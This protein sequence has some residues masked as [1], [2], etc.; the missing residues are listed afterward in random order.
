MAEKKKKKDDYL[1]RGLQKIG[2]SLG[3]VSNPDV[4]AVRKEAYG[5]K[6]PGTPRQNKDVL[7]IHGGYGV[8]AYNT[9]RKPGWA[10]PR[11]RNESKGG[12]RISYGESTNASAM[13]RAELDA[14]RARLPKASAPKVSGKSAASSGASAS[15]TGSAK[16]SRK[17]TP[18]YAERRTA[19]QSVQENY[20]KEKAAKANSKASATT[21]AA[22]SKKAATDVP[23][24]TAKPS[25]AKG[26]SSPPAYTP[27]KAKPQ[28]G[29]KVT[30][31]VVANWTGAG[32]TDM[33]KRGG[34]RIDRGG[35]L[36]GKL[37]KK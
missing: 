32:A 34:A 13:D 26:S 18:S 24:P 16:V 23:K 15:G 4:D 27:E 35:G 2:H 19:M 5:G 3:L 1:A 17:S 14:A 33:Q 28:L 25:M 29:K 21:P 11:V 10:P 37:R 20:R 12:P 31:G 8:Q 36:L 7:G 9:D 6:M 30:S 22:P